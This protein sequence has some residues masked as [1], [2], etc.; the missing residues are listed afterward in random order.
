VTAGAALR[1][2]LLD[3]FDDPAFDRNR[4]NALVLSAAV[5][6]PYLTWEAQRAW[7]DVYGT[8][9]LMLIAAEQDGEV[10]A[11]AP[12]R[13]VEGLVEFNGTSF[14]LDRL[15]VLGE[16]SDPD[17][18]LALLDAARSH[19]ADF[20]SFYFEF[21]HEGSPLNEHIPALAPRLGLRA[22]SFGDM[23]CLELDLAADAEL[24]RRPA[25]SSGRQVLKDERWLMRNGRLELH[26]FRDADEIL[27]RLPTLFDQH[28]RRRPGPE[29][30]SRFHN[31]QV[32]RFFER[33][34]ELAGGT[35]LLRFSQLDWDGRPIACHYGLALG[36]RWF[37]K[38]FSMEPAL[39]KRSPG[40]VLLRQVI[41]AA[42][43]DGA[44]VFDF[45][46]GGQEF[47]R[48]YATRSSR[49]VGW[50]MDPPEWSEEA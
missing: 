50:V 5:P 13:A 48:R 4:W 40:G 16:V 11:V 15:D 42:A 29:D 17:T 30:P 3:G 27:A 24:V 18:L 38:A 20:S 25:G 33:L 21:V 39:A 1:T 43:E 10:V 44:E 31:E 22:Q 28:R 26:Q 49:V 32:R 36:R 12:F 7:H 9:E 19:A 45:G 2:R 47:K 41:L 35:G 6:S 14:E 37:M 8:G 46:T 34:T 23:L